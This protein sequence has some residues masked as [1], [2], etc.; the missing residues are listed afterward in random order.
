VP[1]A[2]AVGTGDAIHT[3]IKSTAISLSLSVV[4]ISSPPICLRQR[5][6]QIAPQ[7][8]IRTG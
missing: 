4:L 7:H 2:A 6:Q 8:L 5:I 1:K 3:V